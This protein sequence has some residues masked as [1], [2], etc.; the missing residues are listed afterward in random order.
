V[1]KISSI[2]P[3]KLYF[4][5]ECGIYEYLHRTH[6]YAPRGEIVEGKIS[7]KKYKRTNII[8]AKNGKKIVAPLAYQGATDSEF[9]EFWFEE[10]LLKETP[11][12]SVFIMDNASFHRIVEP[13][14]NS[15]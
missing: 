14:E 10:M 1:E 5:D 3:E 6:G 13:I 11:K 8:A 15:L 2:S 7:G 4:I 12:N 9:F